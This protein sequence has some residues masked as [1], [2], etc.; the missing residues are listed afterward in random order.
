MIRL[1]IPPLRERPE[2]IL[3]LFGHFVKQLSTQYGIARPDVSSGF[4]DELQ[5]YDWPGNVRELEN[6]AERLL[7]TQ[8]GARRMRQHVHQLMRVYRDGSE[9]AFRSGAETT[10]APFELDPREPLP[11]QVAAAVAQAEDA[12]VRAC[13]RRHDGRIADAADAAGISR[14]TLLRKLRQYGIAKREYKV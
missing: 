6:F 7:I 9:E 4:I 5:T 2:D 3:F 11:A 10:G 14:R 12:Y 1:I 13:L 8:S